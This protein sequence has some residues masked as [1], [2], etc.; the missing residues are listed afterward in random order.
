[1]STSRNQLPS[2]DRILI[3]DILNEWIDRLR[4]GDDCSDAPMRAIKHAIGLGARHRH[5]QGES[6]LCKELSTVSDTEQTIAVCDPMALAMAYGR[7]GSSATQRRRSGV[8]YT[9]PAI[10]DQILDGCFTPLIAGAT[11][12]ATI[13]KRVRI[14]DPACGAGNFL[15]GCLRRFDA[16]MVKQM[17]AVQRSSRCSEFA[18]KCLH[19]IDID[20]DALEVARL[21]L[22][23]EIGDPNQPPEDACGNFVTGDALLDSGIDRW[24]GRFDLMIGNPPFVDSESGSKTNAGKRWR[25]A[26]RKQYRAARGNWDVSSIFVER[27][28]QLLR[29]GGQLGFVLPRRMLGSDHAAA[30]QEVLREQSIESIRI[31][32]DES[33]FDDATIPT[34]CLTARREACSRHATIQIINEDDRDHPVPQ[35]ALAALPPGHWSIMLQSPH[36]QD[37][38]GNWNVQR[39]ARLLNDWPCLR[40]IAQVSDGA[41]TG[42]AYQLK[43]LVRDQSSLGADQRELRL[44]N[45]GTIDPFANL[46]GRRAIRYLGLRLLRPVIPEEQLRTAFPRRWAQARSAKVLVSGLAMRIEAVADET[47]SLLCGKS[48]VCIVPKSPTLAHPLCAWLN[49]GPINTLYRSLFSCRSLGGGSLVIGP[50]QLERLPIPPQFLEDN[51]HR[52]SIA[53]PLDA[54]SREL[55]QAATSRPRQ[56][57]EQASLQKRLDT[58]V[59]SMLA[60]DDHASPTSCALVGTR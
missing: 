28:F 8:Y 55:T 33:A 13:C 11:D 59:G 5:L 40:D 22:W 25:A 30:T 20:P 49:S 53:N 4:R 3:D 56:D 23:L 24:N 45:S 48:A 12:P 38:N 9:P 7:S 34:I 52:H 54:I 51:P 14:C 57:L 46:W 10:V 31:V 41:T 19:G 47:G 44:V 37:R 42:Q 35:A 2:P 39:A 50:R 29:S 32:N 1:M 6:L 60:T 27:G 18:N 26:I 16:L 21:L 17:S 58:L 36:D 43:E 15:I